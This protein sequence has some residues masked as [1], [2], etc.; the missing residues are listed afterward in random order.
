M[1][2]TARWTPEYAREARR[3]GDQLRRAR[4]RQDLTQP[5]LVERLGKSSPRS[6]QWVSDIECGRTAV[7]VITAQRIADVLGYPIA[8]FTDKHF[9]ERR[10][11]WPRSRNEWV[12]LAGGDAGR[13]DAHWELDLNLEE[14]RKEGAEPSI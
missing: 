8:Y 4:N 13:G 2:L 5:Q 1:P 11:Q 9:D 6:F 10:P 14:K 7:D 12:L 3:V